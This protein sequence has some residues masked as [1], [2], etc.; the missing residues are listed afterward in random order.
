MNEINKHPDCNVKKTGGVYETKP[1]GNI[2]QQNF[3]NTA[4]FIKT[5]LSPKELLLF[6][7]ELEI[8]NGRTS[9][10]RWGQREIDIDI[11]F[12]DD[13]ISSDEELT[14]PHKEIELRDFVLLPLADIDGEFIHP[15]SRKSISALLVEAGNGNILKKV[16]GKIL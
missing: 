8:K 16:S 1:Y 11:L 10:E 13:L 5:S 12:Y 15:V 9:S 14:V 6:I 3:Y 2:K 7:K 4:A